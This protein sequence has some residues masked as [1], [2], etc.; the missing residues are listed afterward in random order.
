VV[1]GG[2]TVAAT[3]LV[4]S[5]LVRR[6]RR[7]AAGRDVDVRLRDDDNPTV[8]YGHDGNDEPEMRFHLEPGELVDEVHQ[9]GAPEVNPHD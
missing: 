8:E 2:A 7:L 5:R 1:A 9:G 6:H 4:S 3:A